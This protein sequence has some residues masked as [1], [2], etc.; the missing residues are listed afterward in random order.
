MIVDEAHHIR[1]T[2]T[3]LHHGVRYFCDNA[4]AVVMLTATPVQLGSDDLFTLLNVLRPDLILDRPSFEQM[5]EPNRHVSAAVRHCRTAGPGW[6]SE[7]LACLDAAASTPWGEL[8]I[9]KSPA[10]QSVHHQ[11]QSGSLRDSDR[12]GITRSVEELYTF[13]PLINRTRRRDI[14]AFTTRKPETLTVEFT[15]EQKRLHDG[16]LGVIAAHPR[17]VSRRSERQVH[18]DDS[19]PTGGQ[20]PLRAQADAR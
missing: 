17:P 9:R 2:T 13:S 10:F 8:F 5:A 1:N 6:Q 18:D 7:T 16:V 11:L 20:L 14:G 19:S 4:Q 15:S 12:V 3:F